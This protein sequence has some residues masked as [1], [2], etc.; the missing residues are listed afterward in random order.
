MKI[1]GSSNKDEV[2]LAWLQSELYSKRDSLSP[3]LIKIIDTPDL[4]NEDENSLRESI[5]LNDFG[6]KA[7]LDDFPLDVVWHK[8]ELE[9]V[10]IGNVHILP[11]YDWFLDTDRTFKLENTIKHLK[12]GRKAK[13][14]Y[15]PFPRD[16]LKAVQDIIQ[17]GSEI[18]DIIF[19]ASNITSPLTII[20]GAHR[21]CAL[22][23]MNKFTGTIGYLGLSPNISSSKWSIEAVNVPNWIKEYQHF[24]E[25]G[26]LS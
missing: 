9:S 1:L 11:V 6:R 26:I 24:A 21:S 23:R 10:D 18:K 7:I 16:H 20:E 2:Y 13:P 15:A 12:S 17:D 14:P 19:I 22:V 5:L 8:V 4:S 25:L 3:D